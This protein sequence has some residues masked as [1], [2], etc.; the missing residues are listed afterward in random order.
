MG[1]KRN[2]DMSATTDTVKVLSQTEAEVQT[3]DSSVTNADAAAGAAEAQTTAKKSPKKAATAKKRSG[4]YTHNRSLVDRTR[5]YGLAE[6]VGLAIKTSYTKFAGAITA[7]LVVREVGEQAT[8]TFPHSTGKTVRVEIASDET[9]AKLDAGS[10]DFDVL[11]SE[12]AFVPKLAKYARILG[13]KGM[14]PNPKNGT[15]TTKPA[16]RKK[17]LEA[18]SLTVKTEKK[19]PLCHVVVGKTDMKPE[20]VVANVEALLKA[21]KGRVLK[22]T[23]SASMGPGIKVRVEK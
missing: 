17:E 12:P 23:L 14:M 4:K 16:A 10:V 19:A 7:D 20:A 18:G 22:L 21:F 11:L 1:T 2:V 5:E 6:A 13:P 3:D 8:L 9:L 15:I